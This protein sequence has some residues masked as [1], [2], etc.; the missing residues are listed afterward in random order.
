MQSTGVLTLCVGSTGVEENHGPTCHICVLPTDASLFPLCFARVSPNSS[1][2]R[3]FTPPPHT[4]HAARLHAVKPQPPRLAPPH[5]AVRRPRRRSPTLPALHAVHRRR[6]VPAPLRAATAATS[7]AT[8]RHR[9]V[10]SR[11]SHT[12]CHP[13]S[14]AIHTAAAPRS[15]GARSFAFSRWDARRGRGRKSWSRSQSA[16]GL[17]QNERPRGPR[18]WPRPPRSRRQ[19]ALARLRSGIRQPG[20]GPEVEVWAESEVPGPPEPRLRQQQQS[21]IS[22][23]QL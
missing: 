23:V 15:P 9:R 12:Q 7:T 4:P 19:A 11:R 20:A 1:R 6:L 8:P 5:A 10:L 13:R 16:S 14:R 3:R 22:Q 21:Q 17:V 2:R 18:W